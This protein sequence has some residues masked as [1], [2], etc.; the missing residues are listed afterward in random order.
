MKSRVS[1][2]TQRSSPAHL[3]QEINKCER[4]CEGAQEDVGDGKVCYEDVSRCQHHLV[5]EEGQ[6]DGKV[7]DHPEDNDQ[8]V[9]DNQAVVDT[10]LQS[11][12]T[13]TVLIFHIV[14]G[15]TF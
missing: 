11:A 12:V 9:Q 5:G 4:H 2:C 14:L 13:F 6:D 15:Q 7:A 1:Q 10:R 8:T 3:C